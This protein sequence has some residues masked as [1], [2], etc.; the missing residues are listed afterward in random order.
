[1][2]AKQELLAFCK[3]RL[4]RLDEEQYVAFIADAG[5]RA[6]NDFNVGQVYTLNSAHYC[7]PNPPSDTRVEF[8]ALLTRVAQE[9]D[10]Q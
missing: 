1:M 5:R 7:V 10:T 2:T 8:H 4:I 3:K 6:L 9:E